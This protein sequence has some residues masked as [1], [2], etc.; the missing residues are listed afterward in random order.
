MGSPGRLIP[1]VIGAC[2]LAAAGMS[3][4]HGYQYLLAVGKP[5]WVALITA[6]VMVVFSSTSFAFPFRGRGLFGYALRVL[7]LATVSFSIFS[8][9]A[10]NYNQFSAREEAETAAMRMNEATQAE[11]GALHIQLEG[12]ETQ[13]EYLSQEAAYWKDKSWARRDAADAALQAAYTERSAL[14][15]GIH[16][17]EARGYQVVEVETIFTYVAGLFHIKK[18]LLEFI[19]F[20]IPAVFYDLLAVLALTTALSTVRRRTK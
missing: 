12:L 5:S 16:E 17:A 15:Q 10:V 14:W 9:V 1:A 6:V 13:I 18:S 2:G 19:L 20:C 11:L 8:T 7:G 3:I 4:Y